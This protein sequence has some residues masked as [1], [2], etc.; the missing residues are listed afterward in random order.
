VLG[1]YHPTFIIRAGVADTPGLLKA[2]TDEQQ[3]EYQLMQN[4]QSFRAVDRLTRETGRLCKLI[5][6]IDGHGMSMMKFDRRLPKT[7]GAASHQSAVFY[8]CVLSLRAAR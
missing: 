7:H 2:L 4:E 8:P 5:T 3:V 6:V 1:G